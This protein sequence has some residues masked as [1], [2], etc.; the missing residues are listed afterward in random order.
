MGA[1]AI[2]ALASPAI[3]LVS[4]LPPLQ[5]QIAARVAASG[6][7]QCT[8]YRPDGSS[9][10]CLPTFAL[11][12]GGGVN[13]RSARGAITF[14]RGAATRLTRDEFALLA[15][16]EIAHWYLGHSKSSREAELAADALGA[17]LACA[18]GFDPAAGL[19]LFGYLLADGAH[20]AAGERRAVVLA[21]ACPIEVDKVDTL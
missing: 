14:T 17:K 16:H 11:I 1:L 19:G 4:P 5:Q 20:P 13:G 3:G 2:L 10:P 12:A 7:P 21:A 18:A 8:S 6:L 9:G 15:G